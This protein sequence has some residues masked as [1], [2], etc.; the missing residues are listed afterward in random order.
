MGYHPG[1]E[2]T[3]IYLPGILKQLQ[4]TLF[5]YNTEFFASHADMTLFPNVMAASIRVAHVSV[6]TAMLAWHVG[7]ILLLLWA[8]LRVGRVC[9]DDSAAGLC[10]VALVAALLTIPVAGTSLYLVDQY[11]TARTLST[12]LSLLAVASAVERRF[13]SLLAWTVAMALVHPLMT[14]F[15]IGYLAFLLTALRERV[16]VPAMATALVSLPVWL[17]EPATPAYHRILEMR[18]LHLIT[19]W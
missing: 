5:P 14:V 8:C 3:E 19:N 12:P 7:S 6:G 18:P 2:D 17:L 1:V 10:G 11:V 9:F 16:P 15:T 13:R 4:P